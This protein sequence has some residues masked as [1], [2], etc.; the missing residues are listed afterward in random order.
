MLKQSLTQK[1]QQSLTAAQIQQIKL[2]ELPTMELE[3]RITKELEEN[4]ALDESFDV[5]T[6]RTGQA[7]EEDRDD[8]GD[9]SLDLGDY[10][11]EDDIPEYKLRQL[12]DRNSRHEDIPFAASAPSIGESLMQQLELQPL[13]AR[14]RLLAPY[15]IGNIDPDG[16]L[17][18][19]TLQIEDDLLFK[20]GIE[21]DEAEL[22]AL[23]ARVQA[24]E[25]AG[26]AARNLRECLMIQL[27]RKPGTPA[28]ALAYRLLKDNYE[29]VVNKR[30]ERLSKNLNLSEEEL[31]DAM[32]E[33][34]ALNPKPGNGL[35]DRSESNLMQ[36]HPDFIVEEIDGE[37]FISLTDERMLP[38]LRV[39]PHYH[40]MVEDYRADKSPKSREKRE[41]LN[42]ARQ[43]VEQARWFIQAIEQRRNTLL[44]TM[45]AIAARQ[46]D[47]IKSGETQDLKPMILKDVAEDTGFDISTISRVSNSKY[48]QT[49]HGVYPLKF[50]FSEGYTS[51]DGEE[52]STRAI[53]HALR[54]LIEEESGSQPLSDAELAE[55]LERMGYP[56]ARRT[57][58]KYRQEMGFPT[59]RLRRTI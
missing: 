1:L 14:E 38:P 35:E 41:A 57:V 54:R 32:S 7:A 28:S 43:K 4:P 45:Q 16:Y 48:V 50:F 29:D 42:F 49:G 19:E 47:F 25:P 59:A 30:F 21:A 27:H 34:T 23:I 26:V 9:A 37:P 2:L 17:H 56:V 6:D 36:V 33:I 46:N 58:A 22:E 18:R 39:N 40:R 51:D 15:I 8:M 12:Y 5:P 24:L 3:A 53:K 52:V 20:A 55:A 10:G 11:S 31:S 44:S 13:S